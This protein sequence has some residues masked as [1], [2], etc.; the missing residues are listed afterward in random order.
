MQVLLISQEIF[1]ELGSP[2]DLSVNSIAAWLRYNIGSLNNLLLTSFE[3]TD[4]SAE[5][6]PELNEDEKVI[7][8]KLYMVYYYARSIQSNL[9]AAAYDSIQE[10]SE[11][12]FQI[13]KTNKNEVAKTYLSLKKMIQDELNQ[14]VS[15]FKL[16]RSG[17]LA[18]HGNETFSATNPPPA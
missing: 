12:G 15:G 1:E 3:L 17:P 2:S 5:F 11:D 13:R 6:T 7:L 4:D 18:V 16:K 14:L 8:K 10:Y 9:G